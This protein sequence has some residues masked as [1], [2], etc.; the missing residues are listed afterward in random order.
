[1]RLSSEK[2]N[3]V[4]ALLV[5]LRRG[6]GRAFDLLMPIV[7]E[8]L[9]RLARRHMRGERPGHT[10]QATEL[11]HEAYERL[12]RMEVPW[13]DRLHFF[14]VASRTMRRVLVDHARARKRKKRG[15]DWHRQTL[16]EALVVSPESPVDLLALDDALER[17]MKQDERKGRAVELHYFGG[18]TYEETAQ[19]LG[20]SPV[21][22]HRELKFAKA[23]LFRQLSG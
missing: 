14:A 18:L 12:V 13:E 23:W 8:E 21:T 17:L 9:R 7:Y 20:V 15:G 6:D 1:M 11:L 10:L 19:V 5:R 16:D 22:V 3:D 4:T 2:A